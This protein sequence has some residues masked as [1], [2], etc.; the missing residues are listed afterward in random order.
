MDVRHFRYFVAV[1]E[2]SFAGA[3]RDLNMSQPPLSKRIAD[4]EG[5]LGVKLFDRTNKKVE[6]TTAGEAFLPQARAAV[7]AFDAALRVARSLSPSQSRRIQIALPSETSRGVLSAIVSRLKQ[8]QLELHLIEANTAEQL[9][10]LAAG[11][12]D[13]GVFRYPFKKQGLWV[14]QPLGVI[15][16]AERPL[17]TVDKVHLSDLSPYPLV[18]F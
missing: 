8:E 18:Q 1:A 9:R 12:I 3:A 10:L 6:L 14:G 15:I 11:G 7:Q 2:L 5:A 17:A 4:L 16:A 13:V